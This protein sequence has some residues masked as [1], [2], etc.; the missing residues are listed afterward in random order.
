MWQKLD[1]CLCNA[2]WKMSFSYSVIQHLN[3]NNS[4]HAPL[5]GKFAM[6][7]VRTSGCF[8][9]QQMWIKHSQFLDVVRQNWEILV[10]GDVVSQFAE[11]LK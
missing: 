2:K 10:H 3:R 6:E 1:R 5:L 4:D 9:F 11:K 7:K 8:K